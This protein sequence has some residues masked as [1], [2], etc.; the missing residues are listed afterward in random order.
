MI[1]GSFSRI[2]AAGCKELTDALLR[3]RAED[4]RGQSSKASLAAMQ[5]MA[6]QLA[7]DLKALAKYGPEMDLKLVAEIGGE[8]GEVSYTAGMAGVT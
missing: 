7:P 5:A 3:F 4:R 6:E 2:Q 1:S 8:R